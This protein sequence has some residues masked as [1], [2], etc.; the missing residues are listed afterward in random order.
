V[1]EIEQYTNQ[2]IQGQF[3]YIPAPTY[4]FSQLVT[5]STATNQTYSIVSPFGVDSECSIYYYSCSDGNGRIYA[6]ADIQIPPL[7]AATTSP[8]QP[9]GITGLYLVGAMQLPLNEAWFP[10]KDTLYVQIAGLSTGLVQYV[11][12]WRMRADMMLPSQEQFKRF[13]EPT[14]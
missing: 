8:V 7:T 5:Y 3:D 4:E 13:S 10:V 12:R 6:V 1:S 2:R 11:L 9:Q 14:F